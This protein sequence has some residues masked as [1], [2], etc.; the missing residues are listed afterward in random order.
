MRRFF[1][2]NFSFFAVL[3]LFAGALTWN[4]SH[5]SEALGSGHVFV[6]PSIAVDV[7]L[8][9]G[10]TMPPDPWDLQI[11]H[12]PTMPPDPWDL[13]IAHGPTM[14]PD[15]WDLQ[16]AHGPTMPPDPWDLQ[17]AG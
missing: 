11:A 3:F 14:P 17:I 13:Q 7:R 8:A 4:I 9:H 1:E 5:G 16:I 12:G 6:A 2:S 10:P 15:P